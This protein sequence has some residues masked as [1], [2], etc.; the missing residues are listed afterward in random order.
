MPSP[1]RARS[2]LLALVLTALAA[3][4]AVAPGAQAGPLD[5]DPSFGAGGVILTGGAQGGRW[6]A[7]HAFADGSF[8]AAGEVANDTLALTK[9]RADGTPDPAFGTG[10]LVTFGGGQGSVMAHSVIVLPDGRILVA[11]TATAAVPVI[12]VARISATGAL[13]GTFGT[14]GIATVTTSGGGV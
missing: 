12:V 8:L 9:R 10:G 13:D 14:S 2:T 11:A 4:V 1:R 7:V 5:L 6:S 3:L